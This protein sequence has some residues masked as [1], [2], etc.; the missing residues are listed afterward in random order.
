MD[1][2]RRKSVLSGCVAVEAGPPAARALRGRANKPSEGSADLLTCVSFLLLLLERDKSCAPKEQKRKQGSAVATKLQP[3]SLPEDLDRYGWHGPTR[4]AQPISNMS[5]SL[6]MCHDR[7]AGGA[8]SP[9]VPN[10]P[11]DS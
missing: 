1:D 3:S 9:A 2:G 6:A 11:E 4:W 7:L 8:P 10:L 5:R